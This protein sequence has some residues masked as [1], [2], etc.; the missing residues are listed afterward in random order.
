MIKVKSAVRHQWGSMSILN[1]HYTYPG[2]SIEMAIQFK[3]Y[4]IFI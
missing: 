1:C 2:N 3:K 4:L